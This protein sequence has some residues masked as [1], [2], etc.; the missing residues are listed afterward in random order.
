ML[1]EFLLAILL[2]PTSVAVLP[3]LSFSLTDAPFGIS[4]FTISTSSYETRRC[5][6]VLLSPSFSLLILCELCDLCGEK[7]H[8]FS[9]FHYRDGDVPP[10]DLG[11]CSVY[12]IIFHSPSISLTGSFR[13]PSIVDE[14]LF[15]SRSCF[16]VLFTS[17]SVASS[18]LLITSSMG[19]ILP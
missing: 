19:I 10:T 11:V 14:N 6:G 8:P 12:S 9:V 5:R 3:Y 4:S 15:L 2:F 13:G 17:S 1:M 18:T 7:T 16:A